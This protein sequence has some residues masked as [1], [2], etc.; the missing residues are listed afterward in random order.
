MWEIVRHT[1]SPGFVTFVD[2]QI[3]MIA[4]HQD[5]VFDRW[6]TLAAALKAAGAT[7]ST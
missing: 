2:R 3:A 1:Y 6:K 4:V 5:S 7:R